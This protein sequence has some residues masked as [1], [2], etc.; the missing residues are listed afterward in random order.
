MLTFTYIVSLFF[1]INIFFRELGFLQI[2]KNNKISF[3]TLFED[4]IDE[5][6]FPLIKSIF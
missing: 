4:I 6:K 1:K 3:E 5:K 2:M